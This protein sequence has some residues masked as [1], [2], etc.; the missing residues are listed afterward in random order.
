MPVN[1]MPDLQRVMALAFAAELGVE[2]DPFQSEGGYV[3]Y[4]VL[5]I[6]PSRERALDEVKEQVEQRWREDEIA[7]RLKAKAAQIIDKVKSGTSLAD[8]AEAEGLKVESKSGIKR[9]GPA[10][11]LS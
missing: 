5:G 4:E 8:A 1:D 2:N 11:P 9:A 6:T 7:N 10:S 3:W